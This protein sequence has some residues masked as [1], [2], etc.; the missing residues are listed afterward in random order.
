MA[1]SNPIGSLKKFFSKNERESHT[2]GPEN[3][4]ATA[5]IYFDNPSIETNN[6]ATGYG[7]AFNSSASSAIGNRGNSQ[8]N[9]R[10]V[11]AIQE[12]GAEIDVIKDQ[13]STLKKKNYLE[14]CDHSHAKQSKAAGTNKKLI[15]IYQKYKE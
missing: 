4:L 5:D 13:R 10:K 15:S 9:K 3:D 14:H 2:C 12:H 1:Y 11:P 8:S 7:G 6:M